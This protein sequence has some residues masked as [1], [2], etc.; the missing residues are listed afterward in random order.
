MKNNIKDFPVGT[1]VIAS[2]YASTKI[3]IITKHYSDDMGG[4]VLIDGEQTF[5]SVISWSLLDKNSIEFVRK[6]YDNDAID[7][8]LE[9]Y[10]LTKLYDLHQRQQQ[11]ADDYERNCIEVE[12][13]IQNLKSI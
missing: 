7:Q 1:P 5:L 10:K 9:D 11:L 12:E 3:G 13:M 6:N 4:I 8:A 2:K